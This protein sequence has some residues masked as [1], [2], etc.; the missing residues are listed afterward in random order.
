MG[1]SSIKAYERR[2]IAHGYTSKEIFTLSFSL[3]R[4]SCNRASF[5]WLVCEP[6]L[7][8]PRSCRRL[9]PQR[10]EAHELDIPL[11]R[12]GSCVSLLSTAATDERSAKGVSL[13]TTTDSSRLRTA[14]ERAAAWACGL[15]VGCVS[16]FCI[17][18]ARYSFVDIGVQRLTLRL[19]QSLKLC[20]LTF[21]EHKVEVVIVVF[22]ELV[23][24]VELLFYVHNYL[25]VKQFALHSCGAKF[26]LL[27]LFV[28]G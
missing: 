8:S 27:R 26:S 21:W 24:S 3:R 28:F 18:V 16:I 17:H 6:A 23:L 20:L 10:R 2:P 13:R 15:F 7:H 12:R 14:R 5:E 11:G 25:S 22:V 9:S 4:R 1:M 19:C